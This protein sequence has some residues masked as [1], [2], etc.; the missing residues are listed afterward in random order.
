[1]ERSTYHVYQGGN[2]LSLEL[3]DL[4]A[5]R[6]RAKEAI[7]QEFLRKRKVEIAATAMYQIK[8]TAFESPVCSVLNVWLSPLSGISME[9]PQQ[10]QSSLHICEDKFET[11]V[12]VTPEGCF[13]DL[14]HALD[15]PA[16]AL[17]AVFTTIGKFLGGIN[18]STL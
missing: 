8:T 12:N 13:V 14:H 5:V 2:T 15:L 3:S 10:V 1:M 16:G 17:H 9:P 11:G 6:G 4:P 7:R 18:Y